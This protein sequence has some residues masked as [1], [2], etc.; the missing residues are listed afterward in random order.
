MKPKLLIPVVAILLSACSTHRVDDHSYTYV[1]QHNAVPPREVL[2]TSTTRTTRTTRTHRYAP[3]TRQEE[4]SAVLRE[5]EPID[6]PDTEV[7]E[8]LEN[9][10]ILSPRRKTSYARPAP[11]SLEVYEVPARGYTVIEPVVVDVEG[12][13]KNRPRPEMNYS[14][15]RCPPSGSSARFPKGDSCAGVARE[16]LYSGRPP[17]PTQRVV[18]NPSIPSSTMPLQGVTPWPRYGSVGWPVTSSSGP[19]CMK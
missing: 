6:V 4:R 13:L 18:F 12:F 15:P 10:P 2:D 14:E 9:D 17:V 19:V 1:Y 11:S 3:S 7:R 8:N 5:E 16:S